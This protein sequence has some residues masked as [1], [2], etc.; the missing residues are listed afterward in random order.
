MGDKWYLFFFEP[1]SIFPTLG[2]LQMVSC[3]KKSLSSSERIERMEILWQLNH[4][5]NGSVNREFILV[6]LFRSW[7]FSLVSLS[8][9]LFNLFHYKTLHKISV[10]GNKCN[11]LSNTFIWFPFALHSSGEREKRVLHLHSLIYSQK[12]KNQETFSWTHLI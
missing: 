5:G 6:A 7:F 9:S 4:I 8:L 3:E 10:P 2:Q 12:N 1:F 11:I